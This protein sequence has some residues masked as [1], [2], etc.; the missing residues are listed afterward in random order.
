[1]MHTTTG[2][3]EVLQ[4]G[5]GTTLQDAG[6]SGHRHEGMP[7]SGW[8]DAPLA[9]AANA[10]VGNPLDACVLELRGVG[11]EFR[12]QSGPVRI[13]LAGAVSARWWREDG[14]PIA[15]EA[16]HTATLQTGDRI[17]LNPA[18]SGC[19]YLAVAGGITLP[20]Q[21]GS[22]ASY[23]R[24]GLSGLQGRAWQPG[25]VLPCPTWQDP[26]AKEWRSSA[27]QPPVGPIRVVWGPQ[28]DHFSTEARETFTRTQWEATAEQDRMGLRLRGPALQ[29]TS[30][31]AADIVSDAVTP[32]TIQVPASGQPIV[33]LADSQTVGGYP[34]IATVI[35]AD[36]P[37][38]AHARAGTTLQFQAVS[39]AQARQALLDTQAQWQQWLATRQTFLPAGYIDEQ[40]LYGHNLVSGVLRAEL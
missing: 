38:L 20:A 22:R 19:A 3:L 13:A 16:W 10:L 21:L 30:K 35:T 31:A 29:H 6:R 14:K 23:W 8:L 7:L 28:E 40:A 12:V 33:L 25:D 37:K 27:W 18:L 26:E 5:I 4:P 17:A 24:A 36:L 32:G 11:T 34:K 2:R 1:M 15:L 39:L 9:H